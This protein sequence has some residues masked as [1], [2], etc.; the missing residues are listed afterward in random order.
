MSRRSF[1]V[2]A[3]VLA[4]ILAVTLALLPL[5]TVLADGG[6]VILPH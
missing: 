4:S 3:L 2:R 1:S 5:A 6:S